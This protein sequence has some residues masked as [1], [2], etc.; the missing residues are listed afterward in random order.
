MLNGWPVLSE[1]Q[2]ETARIFARTH[3]PDLRHW[4]LY[5]PIY[6][7]EWRRWFGTGWAL[8]LTRP[9]ARIPGIHDTPPAPPQH[10]KG[11]GEPPSRDERPPDL[12]PPPRLPPTGALRALLGAA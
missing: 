10:A 12:P 2:E 8:H 1:E 3:S 9:L 6:R 4:S 5:H 7:D 11:N